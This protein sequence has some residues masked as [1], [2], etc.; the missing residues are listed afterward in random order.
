[1]PVSNFTPVFNN[2]LDLVH[3][4]ITYQVANQ[5][6]LMTTQTIFILMILLGVGLLLLSALTKS[7]MCNDLSGILAAPFLLLSALQA[8]AVDTVTGAGMASSCVQSI[9]GSC[10]ITEWSLIE[11][12]IIYHY[13]LL[14]VVLGVIFLVSLANL[15]RLW[16]DYRKITEQE[17]IGK[18]PQAMDMG[19][20]STD[21]TFDDKRGYAEDGR[22][23]SKPM[24]NNQSR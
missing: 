14:G 16:L 8:F 9:S 22:G 23:R 21:N 15:Y 19:D 17:Q 3:I 18:G 2:T 13:D 10:S 11:S 4:N 7:D 5:P 20:D 12:H 6:P 1:M 24:R